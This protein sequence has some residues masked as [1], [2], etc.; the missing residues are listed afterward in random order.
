MAALQIP[1]RTDDMVRNA[2]IL[3]ADLVHRSFCLQ[4]RQQQSNPARSS[5]LPYM[6]KITNPYDTATTRNAITSKASLPRLNWVLSSPELHQDF[7]WDCLIPHSR[8]RVNV[9][10]LRATRF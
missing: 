1:N 3:P 9:G 10:K 4:I 6:H 8:R 7:V 2:Y 5:P